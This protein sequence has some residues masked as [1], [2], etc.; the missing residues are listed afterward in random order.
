[1]L[2]LL[3]EGRCRRRHVVKLLPKRTLL[4]WAKDEGDAVAETAR[5]QMGVT[6]CSRYLD[7]DFE[8]AF[9]DDGC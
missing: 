9:I 2:L 1:M 8:I 4:S 5:L 7:D 6:L 3:H